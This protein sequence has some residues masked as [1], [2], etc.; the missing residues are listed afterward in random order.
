MTMVAPAHSISVHGIFCQFAS[1]PVRVLLFFAALL[2]AVI[3]VVKVVEGMSDLSDQ[4]RG[5]AFSAPA[6]AATVNIAYELP[7]PSEIVFGPELRTYSQSEQRAAMYWSVLL[8]AYSS[9]CATTASASLLLS[10]YCDYTASVRAGHRHAGAHYFAASATMVGVSTTAS[11]CAGLGGWIY[12]SVAIASS[13][14]ATLAVQPLSTSIPGAAIT[15]AIQVSLLLLNV[16]HVLP[17]Y[18]LLIP[19]APMVIYI[20]AAFLTAR[21]LPLIST[22]FSTA[23]ALLVLG[24]LPELT[25][26]PMMLIPEPPTFAS[27]QLHTIPYRPTQLQPSFA[28]AAINSFS[29]TLANV[30]NCD[31]SLPQR[32][33]ASYAR[34]EAHTPSGCTTAVPE[35]RISPPSTPTLPS[36]PPSL[37]LSSA[38]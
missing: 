31:H 11:L 3:A 35:K 5:G 15:S 22:C 23:V 27:P 30:V 29:P 21:R 37:P 2:L 18:I 33:K 34:E 9:L 14:A 25:S 16:V 20:G 4:G 26:V 7:S 1:P 24:L 10:T 8:P 36:L 17:S 12:F 28:C 32:L 19:M 38:A 13:L 6:V